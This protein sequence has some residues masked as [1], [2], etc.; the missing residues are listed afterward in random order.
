MIATFTHAFATWIGECWHRDLSLFSE[1]GPVGDLEETI[2]QEYRDDS[3][4]FERFLPELFEHLGID[5]HRERGQLRQR[6]E[7]CSRLPNLFRLLILAEQVGS[8]FGFSTQ[9]PFRIP[10]EYEEAA[11]ILLQRCCDWL[12]S[13][14]GEE[15]Y[16]ARLTGVPIEAYK[17]AVFSPLGTDV[18]WT[19]P[20][21]QN[22]GVLWNAQ[23]V[24]GAP[25]VPARCGIP[26]SVLSHDLLSEDS[27]KE[28][29]EAIG[30]AI[31]QTNGCRLSVKEKSAARL[32]ARL[33]RIETV[34]DYA[35]LV[36]QHPLLV[37]AEAR[38]ERRGHTPYHLGSPIF[39][40][41][42]DVLVDWRAAS[43]EYD[44]VYIN[45]ETYF[46][47]A[48]LPIETELGFTTLSGW[49]P[50]CVYFLNLDDVEL[51]RA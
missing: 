1:A 47:G 7:H 24:A 12:R 17:N 23:I 18:W 40:V 39:A 49:S 6:G 42:N 16:A 38:R 15:R 48:W 41:P 34:E 29:H 43:A 11:R 25:F 33:Y 20:L 31:E 45:A 26:A 2:A 37:P 13:C 51:V 10:Q 3:P 8:A 36:E 30:Q 50:E 28:V 46:T 27:N 5:E 4:A 9:N 35:K 32:P 22:P 14:L 19:A 44:A 21:K